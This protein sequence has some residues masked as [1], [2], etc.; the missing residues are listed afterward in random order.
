MLRKH[1]GL[2]LEL[3]MAFCETRNLI[4]KQ[5][6]SAASHINRHVPEPSPS[7]RGDAVLD[8]MWEIIEKEAN[9]EVNHDQTRSQRV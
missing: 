1:Y 9:K 7:M 2:L 5:L 6:S 3:L 8:S 4:W